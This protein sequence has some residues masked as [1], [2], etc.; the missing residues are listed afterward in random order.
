MSAFFAGMAASLLL[1]DVP[2]PCKKISS[3]QRAK[4]SGP[5]GL[6]QNAPPGVRFLSQPAHQGFEV[7]TAPIRTSQRHPDRAG[8]ER[9]EPAKTGG[10]R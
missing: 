3:E 10:T 4:R 9:G 1:H 7:G 6:P 8:G 2:T 5:E